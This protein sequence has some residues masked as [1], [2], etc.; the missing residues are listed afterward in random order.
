MKNYIIT[1]TRGPDAGKT[2]DVPQT[3]GEL[4]RLDSVAFAIN[5]LSLSRKHC[6]FRIAADF[7][8]VSDLDSAN[9]TCVNG[10]EITS[11]TILLPGCV[12]SVGETELQISEKTSPLK[13][14]ISPSAPPTQNP[15][16][17]AFS[18]TSDINLGLNETSQEDDPKK[19][20]I[21]PLLYALGAIALIALGSAFFFARP[22][23]VAEQTQVTPIKHP[24]QDKIDLSYSRIKVREH[25]IFDYRLSLTSDGKMAAD[26]YTIADKGR[27]HHKHC[28][29]SKADVTRFI[30]ELTKLP[31]N[32]LKPLYADHPQNLVNI[33]KQ[34]LALAI[35]RNLYTSTRLNRAQ[36]KA[37]KEIC[38]FIEAFAADKLDIWSLSL[39]PVELLSRANKSYQLAI[40]YY[41]QRKAKPE[42]LFEAINSYKLAIA[43]AE[44]LTPKPTFLTPARQELK[45]AEDEL[46]EKYKALRFT[47]TQSRNIKRYDEA[48][49]ALKSILQ[50][51][52]D[53]NDDRHIQSALE[54]SRINAMNTKRP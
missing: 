26:I 33:D 15:I 20:T 52:P 38:D 13:Q 46:T 36:A 54:L 25:E 42:R 24:D 44:A 50:M 37:F 9:G 27:E 6:R 40:R 4:G 28:A 14:T 43:D 30:T 3:G 39:S 19:Q 16:E 51:I 18:Q 2:F 10:K 34:S 1:I 45:I 29:L 32:T 22:A 5:D 47:A 12:I 35:G 11:E 31:L 8:F 23:P 48:C 49:Q 41:E 53:R 17:D 7:L 21:R